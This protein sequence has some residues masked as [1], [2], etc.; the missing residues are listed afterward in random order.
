MKVN[1]VIGAPMLFVIALVAAG[2]DTPD[3]QFI[4]ESHTAMKTMMSAMN[5]A[6]TG[7]VDRDFVAM[8]IPHHRAAVE[9]AKSEIREGRSEQL[10]RIAQEIVVTQ[11]DEIVAMR[12]ALAGPERT[13]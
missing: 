2:A 13:R 3:D 11:S 8:M 1:A 10:R 7:D 12:R 9:M 5:V 6:P 4:A